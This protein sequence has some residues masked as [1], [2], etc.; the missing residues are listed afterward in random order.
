M[1]QQ[2]WSSW[3][4]EMHHLPS[5]RQSNEGSMQYCQPSSN[6]NLEPYPQSNIQYIQPFYGTLGP[7]PIIAELPAPLPPA[8]P[9]STSEKQLT[10]DEQLARKL[11]APEQQSKDDEE[12]AQRLQ[13]LEV[14]EARTRSSSNVS[15]QQRPVSMAVPGPPHMRSL[16]QHR[17]SQ[18]LRPHSQSIPM[19]TQVSPAIVQHR[20]TQSLRPHSQSLPPDTP[21]SPGSFGPPPQLQSRYSLLPEVVPSQ[22]LEVPPNRLPLAAISDLPEV[23]THD[24][25][26]VIEPLSD[27]TSAAAYLEEH[28]QVPYPPQ[29]RL[30]PVVKMYHAQASITSKKDWLDTPDSSAWLTRRRSEH[31][32]NPSPAAFTFAF[33][34][35]GGNYRDPRFAWVM[36]SNEQEL[37]NNKRQSVWT[38]ELRLDL[39]SGMRKSEVLNPGGKTNILTTY[40]HASNYDSLRFIGN[41]GKAYLWV[42]HRSLDFNKGSRYDILRHALFVATGHHPDPLYGDIV[43]DHAYWDGF[44]DETEIHTGVICIECQTK[45]IVGQRWKCKTCPDHNICGLCW[46][47]GARKSI[48]ST[49]KLLLTCL[50]DETLYLRSETVDPALVVASLQVLKDWQKH[51]LRRHKD[52]NPKSFLEN[53]ELTRE[54]DLGRLSCW[55]G[56]DLGRRL[57]APQRVRSRAENA[58]VMQN[59]NDITSALGNLADAGLAIAAQGQ[60]GGHGEQHG[61]GGYS[62]HHY[63]GDGGGGGGGGDG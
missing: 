25:P 44:V 56:S 40:V 3:T 57:G 36:H 19:S 10:E 6:Q 1:S 8:P 5:V 37:G 23:V 50:P 4:N 43:A 60:Q 16:V 54:T 46:S 41:D 52:R 63:G 28:R 62:G 14:Q 11:S 35:K 53:E 30:R 29:W 59:P 38:Y 24:L 55:R 42:S 13:Y 61:S 48:D 7:A 9:S 31:L 12:L 26:Q 20:S 49:C 21:W 2:P 45:P 58:E 39:K 47:S 17:S 27:P 34:T 33:K 51:E 15:Q 22:V 32:S 18:S